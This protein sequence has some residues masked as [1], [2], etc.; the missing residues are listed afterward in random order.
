[1]Q[2]RSLLKLGLAASVVMAT[3][4]AGLA[5]VQP[6][7][8]AGRFSAAGRALYASVAQGVLGP[9]LPAAEPLRAQALSAHL[10]RLEAAIAGMPQSVQAE[11]DELTTLLASAPG[12]LALVG[13]AVPWQQARPDEVEAALNGLRHSRIALRQQ[14]YQ[15]LRELTQA[16][17]FGHAEHWSALNYPGQ[18]PVGGA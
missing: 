11:V 14:V 16:A 18:Q 2:R 8:S 10:G 15:A 4:G 12:R 5:L 13:L 9:L 7:R 17:H 6:G 3:A 1:M